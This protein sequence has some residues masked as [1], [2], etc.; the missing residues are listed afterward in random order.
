MPEIELFTPTGVISGVAARLPLVGDGPTLEGPLPLGDARWYPN[1]GRPPSQAGDAMVQPDDILVVV[2]PEPEVRSH[3]NWYPITVELGPY[4]V[5]G[6]IETLPGFDPD[7]ALTRPGG[8]F[9]PL[10]DVRI[11]IRGQPGAGTAERAYVEVN[12][13]AVERVTSPLVLS[14][15]FPGATFVEAESVPVA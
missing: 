11:E 13:Y 12:R 5:A 10:W 15:Y 14:F 1:D 4:Q 6:R 9:V 3:A 7:R 8:S 2:L